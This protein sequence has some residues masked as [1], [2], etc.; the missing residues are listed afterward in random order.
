MRRALPERIAINAVFLLPGMG[1]LDTY[2]RELVGELVAAAPSTRFTV[3]CSPAG[4]EHLARTSWAQEVTL[5]SHPLFGTPGLKAI[6][7]LTVL[8]ALAS[9]Q[10]DLLHSVALTAPLR[11]RAVNILTIADTTWLTGA[12]ID[13]TT[14]LWRLVVPPVARRADRLIAISQAG[15]SDIRRHLGIPADRIDVTLL[16]HSVS[17]PDVPP[18][19]AAVRAR[20]GL[21]AGPLVL[22]VGTRKPHKNVLGLVRAM[23]EVTAQFPDARLVLAGNATRHEAELQA[24]VARL[25]LGASVT[26]LP[27]VGNADLERLYAEAECFVMASFNE[28]FGLPL[29]EAMGR[30]IPVASSNASA[31]PEV[32]G[33]A[34]LLFD[35]Y[36]PATIAARII[37]LLRSPARRQELKARGRARAARLTWAATAEATLESYARAWTSRRPRP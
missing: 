6:T 23:A 16:G 21:G 37:E 13:N 9:W 33:D 22:N 25:G 1:G 2:V 29:L 10:A 30:G 5:T 17:L 34:A 19:H 15:A 27:F 14:R 3:Y 32:A 28:G 36:K 7:E 20:F 4:R 12:A 8:G 26:F 35:P 31:L 11:T 24:E 18:D